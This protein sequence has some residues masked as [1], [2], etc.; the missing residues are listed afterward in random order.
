MKAAFITGA[1]RGLGRGFVDFLLQEGYIVF[2]G[3]LEKGGDLPQAQNFFPI[4]LDVT[5]DVS[6]ELAVMRVL[7]QTSSLH[8]LINNA[9][10]NKNTAT[11]N[12]KDLV[13]SLP[14]LDRKLMLKMFEINAV[15][16]LMVTKKFLPLLLDDPSF[17]IN[18]SS[19]RASFHHQEPG[20]YKGNYGY[21]GSK[22]ALTMLT[23]CSLYDM[24][25]NVKTFAVHP[26]DVKSAM[27]SKG[28]Q[29]PQEQAEKILNITKNWND[30]NN[31]AFL[32]YDGSLF[33]L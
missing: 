16:P 29:Q 2:A 24:P 3:V 12:Q 15:S 21:R 32:N 17:V 18:I 19:D 22:I 27:N 26:G 4:P 25:K 14:D 7:Q 10:V 33:P 6:I 8:L 11:G 28:T 30:K 13:S 9:G 23:F 31:G 5:D 1:D 20:D